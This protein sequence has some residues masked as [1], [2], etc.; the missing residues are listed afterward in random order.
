MFLSRQDTVEERAVLASRFQ[1]SS[2]YKFGV[3]VPRSV[4]HAYYLDKINGDTLWRK[5]I[6]K[7]LG[8]INSFGVFRETTQDDNLNDYQKIPYHLVFDVKFDGRCKARLVADGNWT[9]VLKEDIYSGVVGLD[10][11]RLGFQLAAMNDLL[12]CAADVG[13][14]FLHGYTREKVYIIAGPEFEGLEGKP[15]IIHRGIY[16]LR[17]SA[18]RF[19]E[20]LAHAVRQLG[21]RPSKADPDLYVHDRGT[22]HEYLATYVDDILIF[23]KEPMKIIEELKTQYTLKGVGEPQYYLGGIS[24][25]VLMNIGTSKVFRQP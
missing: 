2:I 20:H 17:S 21:F 6:A 19:H 4:K 25:S 11:V 12:V 18:A 5:A 3:E 16:G 9:E 24:S 14:A 23:S 13:T 1:G 22:Y 7:E 10:T 15:L 8:E